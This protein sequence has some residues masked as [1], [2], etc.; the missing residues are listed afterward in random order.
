MAAVTPIV[1]DSGVGVEGALVA[2]VYYWI[3]CEQ[4]IQAKDSGE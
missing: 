4:R 3:P 2:E 1:S